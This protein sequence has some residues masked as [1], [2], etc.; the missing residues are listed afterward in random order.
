M[1]RLVSII[2]PVYNCE[3]YAGHAIGSVLAQ[4]YVGWELLIINDGSTDRSKDK[5]AE[6][7]DSRIRYFE[8]ENKGVSAARNVGLQH[9]AGDFICFLDSD[10]WLPPDSLE[11]RLKKFSESSAIFFVDGSV[12]I[13]SESG[14]DVE[15]T[16][17]PSFTGHPLRKLLRLSERC[18]FGPSWM[19]RW[20][21]DCH[22]RFNEEIS[23]CEELLFYIELADKGEYS[24]VDRLVYCYRN[25]TNSAMKD[26]KG[27]GEGYQ[28]LNRQLQSLNKL[29]WYSGLLLK[30]KTRKIM[31]LSFV[32]MGLPKQAIKALFS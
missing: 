31:F 26:L 17:H 21:R 14:T 7:T 19:I 10:D 11:N 30:L 16:W 4:S 2:M 13:F 1:E 32:N 29:D 8:Q 15:R 23:H 6:I 22:V 5:I 28:K 3:K 9:A 20:S 24:F 27:L 12:N 18:F 25:R